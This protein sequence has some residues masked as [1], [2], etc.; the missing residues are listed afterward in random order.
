MKHITSHLKEHF[1]GVKGHLDEVRGQ[2]EERVS[3]VSQKIQNSMAKK[4]EKS[5]DADFEP[6]ADMYETEDAFVVEVELSGV[7]KEDVALTLSKESFTVRGEKKAK[8]T[9]KEIYQEERDYGKF[10][11]VFPIPTLGDEKTLAA[12]FKNGLL[13]ITIHKK[14]VVVEPVIEIEIK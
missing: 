14:E 13:T 6:L 5:L 8:N 10:F 3:A 2:L 9:I 4:E 11:R 7:E 12:E 1:E